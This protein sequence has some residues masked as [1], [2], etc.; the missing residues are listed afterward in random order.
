MYNAIKKITKILINI[1]F[2]SILLISLYLLYDF[3]QTSNFY[4]FVKGEEKLYTSEFKRDNNE[5]YSNKRSYKI[6]SNEFNDAMFY[7]S[8]KVRKNTPYKVTC[9]VKTKDVQSEG[10]NFGIGAQISIEDTTE[11]SMAI[12]GTTDWQRIELIFNSKNRE[13]I[14]VGFRLGGYLG[15][16]RGTAWFSD[17]TIEEGIN[18]DNNNWR[19]AC[20]IFES[21]DVDINGKNIKLSVTSN[22]IYDI[23]NTIKRFES[24]CNVLSNRKMSAQCDT[25]IVKE[26]LTKLT[27]DKEYGYY[28]SPENVENQIKDI[29]NTNN[30]DH[31][32]VVVRLGD[33]KHL[34]DIEINDWIGLR[35]NGL[36]WNRIF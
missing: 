8:I 5:K 27:Y 10:E 4:D 32:F 22:D 18:D 14:N 16:C 15:N 3:Y 17:F 6:I 21:T 20:F 2:I 12:N 34:N 28:V 26:P 7:K 24:S 19:Y 36:L 9:M 29:I 30:Y 23:N 11:R 1:I 13:E 35:F 25:Y 33:N 31:I